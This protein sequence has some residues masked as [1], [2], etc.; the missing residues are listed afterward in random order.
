MT[1]DNEHFTQ[2]VSEQLSSIKRFYILSGGR[3]TVQTVQTLQ[4]YYA[5]EGDAHQSLEP[6]GEDSYSD[7]ACQPFTAQE[8]P[9]RVLQLV[10]REHNV[11]TTSLKTR[12]RTSHPVVRR[13][14]MIA[15]VAFV[16]MLVGSMLAVFQLARHASTTGNQHGHGTTNGATQNVDA[17]EIYA[18]ANDVLYR[19]NPT[20]YKPLWSFQMHPIYG[21]GYDRLPG[22][23]S[24]V[25]Y[26]FWGTG[27][28]GYYYYALNTSDGSLRWRFKLPDGSSLLSSGN[29]LI[30]HGVVYISEQSLTK[31]YSLVIALDAS[32][33][34]QLWQRRYNNTGIDLGEKHSTDYATGLQL[35]ATSNGMLYATSSTR[36]NGKATFSL[37]ALSGKDGAVV[38]Q[39]YQCDDRGGG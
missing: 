10:G 27:T 1:H 8:T 21:S 6:S 29:Q 23:P 2:G 17:G 4:R 3:S 28:D 15:A 20:T 7:A 25:C 34:H 24:R 13:M 39:K 32:T 36:K 35:K 38:W 12:S 5:P 30:V 31:G 37:Y 33:G 18:Q 16:T 14:A 9:E 22:R 19:L 11:K 26:Y